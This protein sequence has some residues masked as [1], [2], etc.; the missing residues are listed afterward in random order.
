MHRSK[1]INSD[2]FAITLGFALFIA[3]L[4]F[5]TGL[6]AFIRLWMTGD[7]GWGRATTGIVLGLVCLS[8][9]F[10]G[11]VQYVRYPAVNDVTT[12]WENPPQFLLG[13]GASVDAKLKDEVIA[14]FPNAVNR[15]YQLS[16]DIV[17]TLA[18]KLVAE[19]GWGI[20][21]QRPPVQRGEAGQINATAMTLTGWRDEIS[22][23]IG[24]TN[25]GTRVALRSRSMAGLVDFGENGRRIEAFL[26]S[27]DDRVSEWRR[28]NP[29]VNS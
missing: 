3:A 15:N 19:N 29:Q 22:I 13:G 25:N 20:R 9:L 14:A 26:L 24:G 17:F 28:N 23:S 2:T 21:I 8:P 6:I 10:Y 12:D 11:A 5:V 1:G 4:A 27:L 18:E 16:A 7:R